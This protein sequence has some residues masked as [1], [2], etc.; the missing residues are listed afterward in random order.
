MLRSCFSTFIALWLATAPVAVASAKPSPAAAETGLQIKKVDLAAKH[1]LYLVHVR[2]PFFEGTNRTQVQ[3]LNKIIKHCV[4]ANIDPTTRAARYSCDYRVCYL[5]RNLLSL[6]LTFAQDDDIKHK[7]LNI[8]LTP[9]PHDLPFSK[10]FNCR[11]ELSDLCIESLDQKINYLSLPQDTLIV[12]K[13]KPPPFNLKKQG[14]EFHFSPGTVASC[15]AGW[16]TAFV[17]YRS[18]KRSLKK[19]PLLTYL[20]RNTKPSRVFVPTCE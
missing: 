12:R 2:Y 16:Q 14:I 17:S 15:D 8:A 19:N 9:A 13:E 20:S 18:A 10:V 7:C 6:D 1:K 3:A 4:N 5:D 11:D